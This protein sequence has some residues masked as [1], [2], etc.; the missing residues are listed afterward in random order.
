[1]EVFEVAF[2]SNFK[3]KVSGFAQNAAQKSGEV[4]EVTKLNISINTE[5]EGIKELYCELG[6]YCFKKFINGDESDSTVIGFCEKIKIHQENI[7]YLKERI[8]EI[9]NIVICSS[10]GNSVLKTNEFCGKCGA[11]VEAEAEVAEE[12]VEEADPKK[13]SADEHG[14]NAE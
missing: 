6:E 14:Q 1:M 4:V 5:E 13:N 11:K 10:C 8:N 3:E 12:M 9:K 7:K 2:F